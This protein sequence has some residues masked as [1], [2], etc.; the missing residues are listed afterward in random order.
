MKKHEIL[1]QAEIDELL[2]AIQNDDEPTKTIKV[3]KECDRQRKIKLCDF[4]R[5]DILSKKSLRILQDIMECFA[6]SI[7]T[8]F[9]NEYC[10]NTN[11]HVASID[12]ITREEF[13]RCLS[14]PTFATSAS[15]LGGNILLNMNPSTFLCGILKRQP[16]PNRNKNLS[17]EELLAKAKERKKKKRRPKALFGTFEEKIFTHFF[18]EPMFAH[19][20]NA[21]QKK[22]DLPLAQFEKIKFESNP[23]FLPYTESITEMGILATLEITFENKKDTLY[24]IDIFFNSTVIEELYERKIICDNEKLNIIPLENPLGNVVAELGRC[25]LN[26]NF[27]FQKNQVL[28]L[29]NAPENPLPVLIDDKKCYYADALYLDDS[30]ALR[31]CGK[32]ELKINGLTL[33]ND[34]DFYNVRAVWGSANQTEEEFKNYG[35][36][37]VIE[38]SEKW[39]EPVLIYHQKKLRALA[40]VYITG[41]HFAVRITDVL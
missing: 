30:R 21:F 2:Q 34:D 1:S 5:P 28:E 15:W 8:F 13:I 14:T 4:M 41:G 6:S 31:L 17:V 7:T 29:N 35:K 3:Q 10:F 32:D 33:D 18:S 16:V 36:G 39:N 25:H 12:Q 20:L 38:L 22:S 27:V 23:S 40:K 26:E 11:V 37:T 9:H 19:L 24:L